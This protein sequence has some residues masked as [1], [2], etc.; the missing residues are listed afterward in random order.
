MA[1]PDLLAT[2]VYSTVRVTQL[3]AKDVLRDGWNV[4]KR[5][6]EVGDEGVLIEILK[7]DGHP[8]HFLVESSGLDGITIWLSEFLSDEIE[9][10]KVT[11]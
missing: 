11:Q 5:N 3:H 4:N 10:V 9:L 2:H 6:P 7:A 8:D 1:D